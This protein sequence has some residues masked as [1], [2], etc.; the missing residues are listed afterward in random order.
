M[1]NTPSK[2]VNIKEGVEKRKEG[3]INLV[4]KIKESPNRIHFHVSDDH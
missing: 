3:H 1:I 2:E 4:V